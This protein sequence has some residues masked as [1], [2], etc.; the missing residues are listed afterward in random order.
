ML[1]SGRFYS[2]ACEGRDHGGVLIFLHSSLPSNP[3][4][5]SHLMVRV[6]PACPGSTF[7]PRPTPHWFWPRKGHLLY[8]A[9]GCPRFCLG[10]NLVVFNV[11]AVKPL[12]FSTPLRCRR[13]TSTWLAQ[14][15]QTAMRHL[16]LHVAN[17]QGATQRASAVLSKRRHASHVEDGDMCTEHGAG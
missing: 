13:R 16:L 8:P 15:L 1:A 6:F 5:I 12:I 3:V 9:K 11:Q 14:P 4:S 7:L 10:V 17:P 2:S